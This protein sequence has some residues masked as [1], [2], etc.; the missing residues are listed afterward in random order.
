LPLT[1]VVAEDVDSEPL[2]HPPMELRKELATL[3]LR[4]VRFGRTFRE[5]SKRIES[6]EIKWLQH[7]WECSPLLTENGAS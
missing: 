5:R 6:C 4:D 7:L 1:L 3:F 2:A